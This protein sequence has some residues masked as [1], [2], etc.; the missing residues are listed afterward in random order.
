[1]TQIKI[2]LTGAGAPGG[3]GI[4]KAL[5]AIPEFDLWIADADANASGRGLLPEKFVQIP[6]ATEAGFVDAI[7]Q[8][9]EQKG[10]QVVLPLVTL[11]LFQF[12]A[13]KADFAQK[14]IAI[15]VSENSALK[16]ANNKRLL[17][18]HLQT[19]DIDVP[20][21]LKAN[22]WDELKTAVHAI[23]YPQKLVCIKPSVSNG[24]RGFRILDS[25]YNPFT[26]FFK[27]K[28]NNTTTTLANLEPIF[29][30]NEFSEM[31][32][33]AHLPGDEYTIDAL[34]YQNKPLL[35]L[36]RKRIAMNN[37]ITIKGQF[38]QI[39]SIIELCQ[40]VLGSLLLEGP[41][42]I[43]VKANQEGQYQILEINPRLQGTSIAAMGLGINLP[44]LAV[45]AA[46]G[47]EGELVLPGICW[48]LQ[49]ARYYDEIY[50]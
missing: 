38:L 5:L 17:L 15:V 6:T 29:R 8:I 34:V 16:I 37:G 30:G 32:V 45:Y 3:P 22:T 11:E 23:G 20:V 39:P 2:L 9:C 40:K 49:F 25:R 18:E 47:M 1:M 4:I 50:F 12:A 41:I 46:L 14:N 42:G 13:C 44:A 43:Q 35:I 36:P 10:I 33:T 7:V 21:F 28:P 27:E 24:S 19:H 48:G 26:S 31:L